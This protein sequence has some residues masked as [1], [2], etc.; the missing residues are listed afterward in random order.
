MNKMNPT[1]FTKAGLLL[2]TLGLWNAGCKKVD[3]HVNSLSP[4]KQVN[5]VANNDEYVKPAHEDPTLLNSW[6][7]AFSPN[8]IAW[9]AS[10]E[11]HVSQVYNSEGVTLIPPVHIPSPVNTEGDG[12]PTGV[13]FNPDS[14]AFKIPSGNGSP[15]S[16]ARFIFAGLDGVI[17]GWNGTQG[18]KAFRKLT[19]TGVYTGLTLAMRG[20]RTYLY[21]AN[22]KDRRI[23]VWNYL[24][25]KVSWDFTDPYL[26]ADYTPFNIQ[27]VGTRLYV[28]YAKMGKEDEEKGPGLGLVSIFT[29][30]GKF[31]KRFATGGTLNAPWGVTFA[32]ASACTLFQNVIYVGNFG[33]GRINA[34]NA[35]NGKFLGQVRKTN[36]NPVV[37]EGLWALMF[38]PATSTIDQNR[39]Y[40]TAGPDD[41]QD[42]LFGY[43]MPDMSSANY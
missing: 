15:A 4:M 37:I 34:Y 24:W 36:G 10:Q 21:A 2:L 28:M 1:A 3:D 7:L 20:D 19:T 32:K 9:V 5:L 35:D 26:P 8:G 40:F 6:G 16:A 12:N 39:L 11:G 33:D 27:V 23:D 13:V 18:T 29:V 41:E 42:G 38:P 14:T 17:S 43:L 22:F 31:V 25:Q 30:D